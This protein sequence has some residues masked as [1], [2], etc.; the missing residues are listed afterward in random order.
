MSKDKIL[1]KIQLANAIRL[2]IGGWLFDG[3]DIEEIPDILE[4]IKNTYKEAIK[5]E[6]KENE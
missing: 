2:A 6:L 3:G 4:E 5:K 1:D